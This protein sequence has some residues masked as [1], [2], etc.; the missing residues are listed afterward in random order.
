VFDGL[1]GSL[2]F[3]VAGFKLGYRTA[4]ASERD[5]M[6]LFLALLLIFGEAILNR[7]L[8]LAVL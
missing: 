1:Q 6:I 4:S 2:R 5:K 7:A 8:P 3:Q